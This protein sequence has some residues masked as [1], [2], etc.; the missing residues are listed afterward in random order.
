MDNIYYC[1]YVVCVCACACVCM[2]M[3][4]TDRQTEREKEREIV[5]MEAKRLILHIFYN[6]SP[7]F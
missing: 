7:P 2:F 1:L 6:Y 3:C 5:N 4:M